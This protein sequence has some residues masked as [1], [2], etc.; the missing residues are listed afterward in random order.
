MFAT[1]NIHKPLGCTSHDVVAKLRRI[2]NLKKIG[3][4][5]TL[6][7][8]AEGVL[9]VCLGQATRLIEYFPTHK[10]YTA[11]VTLGRTTTTLDRE[12]DTLSVTS[13][14]PFAIS[15]ESL[16]S[17]LQRFEGCIQ[18]QVPLYSAVHV[19]GK[20]LYE[21]A[22]KQERSETAS[23]AAVI[24]LPTREVSIEKLD[25]L[26][27]DLQD[28]AHPILTLDVACS[29]GTYIRSLARDIGDAIG[30]GAF[31]SGLVRTEHGHFS[32]DSAIS[33]E[34]LQA[35]EKPVTYLLN[36]LPYLN[37]P[38]L[39]LNSEEEV[40]RLRFGQLI[41]WTGTAESQSSLIYLATFQEQPIGVVE[42]LA[43]QLKPLKIF[44]AI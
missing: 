18:Q 21:L 36:P 19:G 26:D 8:L 12:G 1:L 43:D 14:K 39:S 23:N 2:F 3:H 29:S 38:L 4:L 13:C 34:T 11:R 31:L 32:L 42:W 9:P 25:L 35:A 7:P 17:I 24:E 44:P 22:R 28:P 33:L 10:R 30:C 5:G 27:L 40:R 20:K 37:I 15:E 16:K 6:D 41:S